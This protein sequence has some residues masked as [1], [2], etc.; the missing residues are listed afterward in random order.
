MSVYRENAAPKREER[1]VTVWRIAPWASNTPR[2][3]ASAIAMLGSALAVV[4]W[5]M[6]SSLASRAA[7]LSL[8][9][10]VVAILA[11]TQRFR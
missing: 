10:G 4:W 8:A 9:A 6:G 2:V 1:W 7:A 5:A 3:V 11:H